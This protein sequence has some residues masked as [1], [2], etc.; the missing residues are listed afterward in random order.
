MSLNEELYNVLHSDLVDVKPEYQDRDG[1]LCP[2][3][4]R[5]ITKDEVIQFGIEHII[6]K[7]IIKNDSPEKKKL[8]TLN[9]RCGITILCRQERI[10][11]Y[12]G[13]IVKDGCNSLKGK[14]YDR[15]W[16]QHWHGDQ[17]DQSHLSHRHGVSILIMAYLG[18]FQVFG[19]EYILQRDFD[20]IRNQF[21]Y[22]DERM[23]DWLDFAQVYIPSGGDN[24]VATSTGHPFLIGGITAHGHELEV[25]FR[26]FKAKLPT[27]HWQV[28]TGAKSLEAILPKF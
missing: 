5:E 12:D 8:G 2:I 20:D 16:K 24:I 14:I 9:Q 15:L 10:C 25:L 19:Y 18:A 6:P 4:L 26:R 22:S 17:L 21:D 13:K 11:K 28:K 23:T 7:N 3:C 1:I 27:G